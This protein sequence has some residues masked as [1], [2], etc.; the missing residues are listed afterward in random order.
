[1]ECQIVC[2]IFFNGRHIGYSTDNCHRSRSVTSYEPLDTYLPNSQPQRKNGCVGD[3]VVAVV[4]E[5]W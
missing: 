4:G 1:L 2:A 5:I 3:G